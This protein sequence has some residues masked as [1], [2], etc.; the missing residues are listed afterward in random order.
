M[1]GSTGGAASAGETGSAD[2]DRGAGG[3]EARGVRTTG[4]DAVTALVLPAFALNAEFYA[5]AD[6]LARPTGLSPAQWQVLAAAEHEPAP[7]AELARRVGLGLARQSVQ[8]VADVLV[9]GGWAEYAPNPGHRR[10]KLLRTTDAGRDVVTRLRAAQHA[11]ADAVG[12][13]LEAE[14]V[15]PAELATLRELAGRV[16]EASRRAR[17][18]V[19]EE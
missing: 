17:V 1:S 6:A 10:A 7:V 12:R 2:A 14:G 19:S 18:A 8:R 11:W 13:E 5:A 15:E 16:A 9:A 3:T 4:G